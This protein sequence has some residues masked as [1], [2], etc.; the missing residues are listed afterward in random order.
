MNKKHSIKKMSFGAFIAEYITIPYKNLYVHVW[1]E[2]GITTL[3]NEKYM[4]Y[5]FTINTSPNMYYDHTIHPIQINNDIIDIMHVIFD[6]L[7]NRFSLRVYHPQLI[8]A[9]PKILQKNNIKLNEFQQ[10]AQFNS[11]FVRFCVEKEKR[12]DAKSYR[13]TKSNI[14][15]KR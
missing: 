7:D 12:K 6:A 4:E 2:R 14:T 10:S 9:M 8:S 5:S 15:G 11:K 1:T 13:K 3:S